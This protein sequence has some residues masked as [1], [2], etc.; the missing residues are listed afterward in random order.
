[1]PQLITKDSNRRANER[2][3]KGNVIRVLTIKDTKKMAET[4]FIGV[5][6]RSTCPLADYLEKICR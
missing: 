3:A 6:K 5:D 1:M 4:E 2:K